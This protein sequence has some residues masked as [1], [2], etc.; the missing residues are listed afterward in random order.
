MQLVERTIEV[1]EL[2][3]K[4]VNGLR[5]TEISDLLKLPRSSTHRLLNS[6]KKHHFVTQMKDTKK[7]TL[8]YKVIS[9]GDNF[10]KEDSL[11]KNS[12]PIMEKLS[13]NVNKTVAL[14]TLEGSYISTIDYVESN[15]FMQ[16]LVRK[17][18]KVPALVTSAGKVLL[19]YS[20]KDDIKNVYIENKKSDLPLKSIEYYIDQLHITRER[21]YSLIDEELQKGVFGIAAPI[22]D[23]NN[24]LIAALSI[25]SIKE[26]DKISEELIK[27]LINSANEI[28]IS[29]GFEKDQ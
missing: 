13:K 23:F 22:Y 18:V 26:E 27:D 4:D 16:L 29:L 10:I 17:D 20:S 7:Y 25:T 8:G 14:S 24:K 5:L 15:H 19:S 2:L 21:G 11:I 1:L 3:S 28:S 12:H 6:L 9:I